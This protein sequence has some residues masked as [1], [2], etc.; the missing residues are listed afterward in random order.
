[1]R[2]IVLLFCALF[3][4]IS[5]AL[6]KSLDVGGD[7]TSSFIYY[8]LDE[9]NAFVN[10]GTLAD[11][12]EFGGVATNDPTCATL[13]PMG[14]LYRTDPT[15]NTHSCTPG[16]NGSNA[17]CVSSED[18]CEYLADADKAIRIEVMLG[19]GADGTAALSSLSFYEQAPEN[20][21]WNQGPSGPNNYP[22]LYGVRILRDGNE[23]YRQT[24][25]PTTTDWTLESFDFSG[26]DFTVTG[27]TFFTIELLG[28]CTVGN[29]ATVN[30]WDIDEVIITSSCQSSNVSG[31]TIA[32]DGGLT[33]L[34]ICANDGIS[35]AFTVIVSNNTGDN[36]QIVVTD[37]NGVVLDL[38]T[39]NV[40][41][42]EGA[43][44]GQCLV[45]NLSYNGAL[46]GL[47][48]GGDVNDVTGCFGLS[49]P[50]VVN[51]NLQG[52]GSITTST[53]ATEVSI[54]VGDGVAD[55]ID[56]ILTGNT[57][58]NMQWVITDELG[59]ILALPAGPPFDLEG[60]GLGTCL[61]WN[62][63]FEGTI[64]GAEIG[65]NAADLQGCFG[66]SNPIRVIRTTAAA[67][68]ISSGGQ[69]SFN[70]CA[71]D[72]IPDVITVDINGGMGDEEVYVLTD[73]DGNILRLIE[74]TNSIDFDGF[75][76]GTCLL[77]H[78]YYDGSINGLAVGNNA[79]QLNGCFGLSNPI[80]VERVATTGGV[81]STNNMTFVNICEG[82]GSTGIIETVLNNNVGANVEYFLADADGNVTQFLQGPNFDFSSFDRGRYTLYAYSFDGMSSGVTVGTNVDQLTGACDGL[83]NPIVI[84]K[85]AADG[86]TISSPQ[87]NTIDVC[88]QGSVTDGI[89]VSVSGEDG[90]VFRWVITDLNGNIIGLPGPPPINI[91]ITGN[92][93]TC[94]I[95]H[96]AYDNFF[97]GLAVGNNV[98][99]F[100]GCFD[101][102][103]PI[104]VNKSIA[105]G[106]VLSLD[107]NLTST[108]LCNEGSGVDPVNVV[109]NN[110]FGD[111][112]A[113]VITDEAGNILDLPAGPPFDFSSYATGTYRIWNLSF[114]GML[115][116]AAVGANAADLSG[117]CFDLSNSVAVNVSNVTTPTISSPNGDSFSICV[118]GGAS[119]PLEFSV[120][121]ASAG[122][123]IITDEN[124]TILDFPAGPP[125]TLTGTPGSTCVVWYLSG[126]QV[127]GLTIGNNAS[128]LTGCFALS[129]PITVTKDNVNG[130]VLSTTDNTT[131]V[132]VCVGDGTPDLVNVILNNNTGSNNAW[133][134]TDENANILE[135]P[136]SP[137]FDF[138]GAGLG[139]CLIWNLSF[140]G[141]I[142]G[143]S[144]GANAANL[145][146]CFSL[147]NP[148]TVNRIMTDAGTIDSN[149][150]TEVTICLD[151]PNDTVDV[152]VTG[153]STGGNKGWVI[154]DENANILAL[155]AG[156][157]FSFT[158]AG[159][160]TCL[161][162]RICYASDV[163]GIAVGNN[164]GD[165]QGC[166]DLSNPITVIREEASNP[167]T[168]TSKLTFD[169][170][171]CYSDTSDDSNKDYSEFTATV[172][173][174]PACSQ[175]SVVG[176]HLYRRDPQTNM[177]SCTTGAN[178][179]VAMCV[180][181]LDN[182]DFE[183]DSDLAIRF[184][185]Q[186][187][188]GS[189]GT[190][191]ISGLSFFE[192][193]PPTY[194]WI[195][196]PSGPNN[197][198]TN[199]G[200]RVLKDG[201]EI[202]KQVG[203]ATTNDYT[204]QTFDFSGNADFSVTSTSVFTFEL[205]GY[206]LV[207][208]GAAV[209]AWDV[210]EIMVNST[211]TSG[212][213]DCGSSIVEEEDP[214]NGI[215]EEEESE[216]QAELDFI[217]KPNPAEDFMVLE[218]NKKPMEGTKVY[219][220]DRVG[221][222]ADSFTINQETY[223][224]D[225]NKYT[226]GFYYVRIISEGSQK[227][228]KFYKDAR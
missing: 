128:N 28:Y 115:N 95:W 18:N 180:S 224:V 34:D 119:D 126:T 32:T 163:T 108:T 146:G 89:D 120:T 194:Q 209:A 59:E 182:C 29:G 72:G 195:N 111:N 106:G 9:C 70:I 207:G 222:L 63:S 192:A 60:A 40:I 71:S 199:Y 129:N 14:T 39:G 104:T 36:S 12:S 62:L 67:S 171:G 168:T 216:L 164:A 38:P 123:W 125:F 159:T 214:E 76:A 155:P 193:A 197:Y 157:P 173:N 107:G 167:V 203:L 225:L 21:N 94:Q 118:D 15:V 169:M 166:F 13:L 189:A 56:V 24:G 151:D 134:I 49:N 122:R 200:V 110:Q 53:G 178:G 5:S 217:I 46:N 198:P 112:A 99:Q 161:V 179:S 127:S 130:G 140:E 88:V 218:L 208:N 52:G 144:V 223:Q 45:W 176:D 37:P 142:Q 131:E 96:L 210:D 69:T 20:Y 100:E 65:S 11:Y 183:D 7:T 138:D 149:G 187:V 154:T 158:G 77:W 23:I 85:G 97:T 86:G 101:L 68:S 17:M 93:Q 202:F 74:G 81:F 117:D 55:P 6:A 213:G 196:G 141:D 137:P 191:N 83:S 42:F 153:G 41:D 33:T 174:D 152:S 80:T 48:V 43:G 175:L 102:S 54:C 143:A 78:L 148:I 105:D 156:P 50:I 2:L 27:N 226:S 30:A 188:P 220:F 22:T 162:W 109:L 82:D 10:A 145:Q 26:P 184:D 165:L 35:D 150:E 206:C 170:E 103:N 219:I 181:S 90:T 16:V 31:G 8:S 204:L 124:G 47:A 91:E 135:L 211:C 227:I 51:R 133:V 212:G 139:T 113:W 121:N 136:S 1:M 186:V 4:N 190:G 79:S 221:R 58:S 201:V 19:P 44:T 84:L 64:T 25:I 172:E 215:N 87:G 57:G 75:G 147:S 205:L 228:Q 132:T 114:N 160:G 92:A 73:T 177:H 3:F 98:S 116:G 66:L 185:I 61:I